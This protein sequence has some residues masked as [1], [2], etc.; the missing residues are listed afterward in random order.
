MDSM[1]SDARSVGTIHSYRQPDTAWSP[2]V[3]YYHH[4]TPPT[5]GQQDGHQWNYN[6][7]CHQRI[8]NDN[9]FGQPFGY[10]CGSAT[11]AAGQPSGVGLNGAGQING[12]VGQNG[13]HHLH[14][15][16]P[17]I[18]Q[19]TPLANGQALVKY[20]TGD[21]AGANITC[22]ITFHAFE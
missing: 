6:L 20:T 2:P 12:C 7:A 17:P 11:V 21:T 19:L 16:Q 14:Q 18:N 13:S 8:Y 10:D 9:Q 3:G 4:H 1:Y 22:L 5:G 15:Q